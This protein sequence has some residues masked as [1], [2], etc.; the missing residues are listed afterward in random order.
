MC[1]NKRR[2]CDLQFIV[3][4]QQEKDLET[5]LHAKDMQQSGLRAQYE[6][7]TQSLLIFSSHA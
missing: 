6:Q 7:S 4:M 5:A 2:V 1:T 3:Q